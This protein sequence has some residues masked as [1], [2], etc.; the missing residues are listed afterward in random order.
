M[1]EALHDITRDEPTPW[2]IEGDRVLNACGGEVTV[3]EADRESELRF[4]S[5]I[6]AAV[7]AY[8]PP[9]S[10]KAAPRT[11]S[12]RHNETSRRIMALFFE[13]LREGG[14][15]EELLIILE[16]V[17]MGTFMT[18]VK[19]GGDKAV[20]DVMVERIRQRLAEQRLGSIP[21]RGS[22]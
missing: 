5:F 21:P 3:I 22:A 14:A 13:T 17:F 1:S 15:K 16:S 20:F 12:Q 4:W 6:V 7:N 9:A 18:M 2:T 19:L 11:A 10:L 8:C